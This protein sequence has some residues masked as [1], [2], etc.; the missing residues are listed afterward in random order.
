V[1][2][3]SLFAAV[4]ALAT[5]CFAVVL[6]SIDPDTYWHLASA[7]WMVDHGQ[8]L[9]RDPFSSTVAGQ[10]YSVGEWAG[11]LV[12]YAAYLAGGWQGIAILRALVV[13]VAA[14]FSARTILLLQPRPIFAFVPLLAALAIGKTTWTDRPQLFTLALFAVF[15]FVLMSVRSGADPRRLWVLPPLAL[16][17]T[18]LH[19]GYAVGVVLIALF[20]VDA[21]VRRAAAARVLGPA[22]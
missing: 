22:Q 15:F 6:P 13:S 11:E 5:F 7:K 20:L 4:I 2:A 16:V 19:G 10:P 9:T 12:W 3:S 1:T 18:N 14:L 8:L 21:L 17:W